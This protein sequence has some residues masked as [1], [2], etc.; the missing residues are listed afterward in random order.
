MSEV[1]E[2]PCIVIAGPTATGKTALAVEVAHALGSE[3]FSMDSRQVYRGMDLGTGKDLQEYRRFDKPVPFHLIDIVNPGEVYSLFRFQAD[4]YTA[5]E[6]FR[7]R[8]GTTVPPVLVG[9]TGLYLEA[10]LKRYDIAQVPENAELREE[11]SLRDLEELQAELFELDPELHGRTDVS[12]KRRVVRALE[13]AMSGSSVEISRSQLP[14]WSLKPTIF[15][16]EWERATLRERIAARLQAR[17]D[18]GLV[19]EVRRLRDQG[20]SWERLDDLGM[21]Y[22]E[23]AAY[24]R[25]QKSFEAMQADLLHGIHQLAKRQDTW[26]RGMEKRGLKTVAIGPEA[27]VAQILN[28]YQDWLRLSLPAS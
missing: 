3:I 20:L 22:R 7:G 5:L 26:F 27:T 21:E 16:M 10:V 6:D 23:V 17:L 1:K 8:R 24:L 25:G 11:L 2:W 19:N 28:K 14:D 18:A 15:V 12:N 13:I 4:C 9:G